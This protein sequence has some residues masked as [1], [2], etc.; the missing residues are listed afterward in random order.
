MH[1]IGVVEGLNLALRFVLEI[2]ALIA[3]GYWGFTAFD[4]WLLR[5]L[6]G[7][8]IPFV[9]AALWGVFRVPGDGGPP[10]IAIHS[11]LRLAL[12]WFVFGVAIFLLFDAGLRTAAWIFLAVIVA[13]YAVGYR[14]TVAF[15]VGRGVPEAR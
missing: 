15:L 13:H 8:G 3:A 5:I 14:R 12:E 10:V 6:F 7:I 1:G 2:L 4:S 11:A 9:L